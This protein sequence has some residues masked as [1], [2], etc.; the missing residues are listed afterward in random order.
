MIHFQVL[1]FVIEA[2]WPLLY[3]E[4]HENQLQVVDPLQGKSDFLKMIPCF[5]S[6]GKFQ[7]N[8]QISV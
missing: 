7:D 6:F 1:S 8:K 3:P 4:L 5:G 2:Y